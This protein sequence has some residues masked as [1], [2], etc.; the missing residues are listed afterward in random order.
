MVC[1]GVKPGVA[2]WKA[3]TNPLS[4]GDTPRYSILKF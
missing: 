1:L 3:E 2:E 4:Y